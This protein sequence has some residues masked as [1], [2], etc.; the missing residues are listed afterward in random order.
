MSSVDL[1]TQFSKILSSD[2][3]D[4]ILFRNSGLEFNPKNM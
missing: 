1:H 2:D 3:N 4:Q